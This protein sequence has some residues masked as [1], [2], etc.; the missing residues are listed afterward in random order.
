[1]DCVP[2]AA[3]PFIRHVTLRVSESILH[4]PVGFPEFLASLPS[5]QSVWLN[6][7]N[8]MSHFDGHRYWTSNAPLVVRDVPP[9]IELRSLCL[10]GL[11]IDADATPD[12]PLSSLTSLSFLDLAMGQLWALASLTDVLGRTPHLTT[13]R[14]RSDNGQPPPPNFWPGPGASIASSIPMLRYLELSGDVLDLY[15]FLETVTPET[16]PCLDTVVVTFHLWRCTFPEVVFGCIPALDM[17]LDNAAD[18]IAISANPLH[19]TTE[20][21]LDAPRSMTWSCTWKFFTEGG[22]LWVSPVPDS[23]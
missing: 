16:Y 13:L 5:L 9:T 23:T 1:M 20:R 11:N 10:D 12:L 6:V 22:E 19:V 7:Y 14:I 17:E 3:L 2:F 15:P 21:P 18:T 4:C 8:G